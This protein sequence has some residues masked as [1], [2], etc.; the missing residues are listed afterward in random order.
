MEI[1]LQFEPN[2]PRT[3]AQMKKIAVKYDGTPI[4][5]DSERLVKAR[6]AFLAKLTPFQPPAPILGPIRLQIDWIFTS[7][8]IQ[9]DGWKTTKPDTDNLVKLLKD[10]MTK[11]NFWQD[12]AQICHEVCRK[13]QFKDCQ[14]GVRIMIEE[15]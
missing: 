1:F 15:L 3:T 10:C 7:P 6:T 14:H 4:V 9:Y 11:L 8:S 12:D 5:Y 13:F 2:P